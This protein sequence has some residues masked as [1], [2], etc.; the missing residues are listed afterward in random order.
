MFILGQS[1]SNVR[2]FRNVTGTGRRRRP[3]FP[4]WPVSLDLV[5]LQPHP[6]FLGVP[7]RY[8][9]MG[10]GHQCPPGC[11]PDAEKPASNVQPNPAVHA[12]ALMV[13]A[14][15]NVRPGI[16]EC[17][18]IPVVSA[19]CPRFDAFCRTFDTGRPVLTVRSVG[20]A[21]RISCSQHRAYQ[22]LI[23]L[24]GVP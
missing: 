16:V 4:S 7:S 11:T 12:K 13:C 6:I 19:T 20:P 5:L 23:L 22:W 21:T 17:G 8:P 14:A 9:Q 2:H 1:L 3:N 10:T 18:T 24:R 15:R